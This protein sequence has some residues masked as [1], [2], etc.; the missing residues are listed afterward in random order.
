MNKV[1]K[2][3]QLEELSK[4]IKQ[5]GEKIIL[6]GGCFDILHTGHIRFLKSAKELGGKLLVALESDES[7]KRSKGEKRPV[8][9]QKERANILSNLPSVDIIV[10][11][12]FLEGYVDY[13][14]L[15]EKIKPD[16]IAV[17]KGDKRKK[18]KERQARAFGAKVIETVERVKDFS[19]TNIIKRQTNT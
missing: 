19:T 13:Y 3:E 7:V 18:E 10:T 6:V 12:P 16:I 17:T 5:K 11:L 8:N 14:R 4:K 15:V 2:F 9:N 1:I